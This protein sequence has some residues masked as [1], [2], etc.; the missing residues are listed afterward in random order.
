[1]RYPGGGV[2]ERLGFAPG[3][4][5]DVEEEGTEGGS[6]WFSGTPL[7]RSSNDGIS[8]G[9]KE[10]SCNDHDHDDDGFYTQYLSYRT[11]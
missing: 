4:D 3:C 7:A 5:D 8:G 1:M 11:P 6:V 9:S 10:G 2:S